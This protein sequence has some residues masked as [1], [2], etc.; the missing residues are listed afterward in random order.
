MCD[1][2]CETKMGGYGKRVQADETFVGRRTSRAGEV[3]QRGYAEKEP[4][5]TLVDGKQVRSFHVPEVNAATLKPILREQIDKAAMVF[6]DEATYYAGLRADFP[7]GHFKVQHNIGEYGRGG[8]AVK[9]CEN[10]LSILNRGMYR[11]Y[12]PVSP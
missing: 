2:Y 11:P 12:Q 4:V 10:Y 5:L 8:A 1:H 6:T 9:R 7:A 3:R